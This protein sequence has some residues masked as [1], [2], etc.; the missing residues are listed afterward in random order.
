VLSFPHPT[1]LE[2]NPTPILGATV[3]EAQHDLGN[4]G[5]SLPHRR[6]EIQPAE[7]MA[8]ACHTSAPP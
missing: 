4:L 7:S 5:T 2:T 1:H 8:Q 6:P 3:I